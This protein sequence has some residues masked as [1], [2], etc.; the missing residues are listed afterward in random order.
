MVAA[1]GDF[2]VG[3]GFWRGEVAGCGF[4][5]EVGG[6]HVRCALPI[7]AAEASLL[8]PRIAFGTEFYL[9]GFRAC[10]KTWSGGRRGFQP[11]HKA[12]R[13]NA[14]FSRGGML[15]AYFARRFEFF[16]SL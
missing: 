6:Q 15:F 8:L 2:D 3:R 9:R 11:P 4:V 7:I 10:G 1:F 12:N 14:G 13:I 5:V 16:R